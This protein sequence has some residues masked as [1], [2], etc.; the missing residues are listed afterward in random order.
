[1][2]SISDED[3]QRRLVRRLL[4]GFES[5]E[6]AATGL[7]GIHSTDPASVHLAVAAR[8]A[9]AS[10]P[11]VETALY[12]ERR[13]VR[14]LGM[15]R[16]L[17]V[18]PRHL[19]A[20]VQRGYTDSFVA[21]ERK[22]LA[23]WLERT[24]VASDG[25]RHLEKMADLVR[26]F[27]AERGE[28]STR[29]LTSAVPDLDVRFT[30]PVGSA[31]GTVSVGSRVVL[32]MTAAGDLVR[33]RPLGS[34]ISAQYRYTT[35]ERWLGGAI[36]AMDPATA[37]AEL[38]RAWLRR[39]GP[40]T[41]TDLQWWTGWNLTH[42]RAALSAVGVVEVGL[43]SG[44]GYLLADDI[45]PQQETESVALLPA[46]DSTPMGWKE[47]DSYLGDHGRLLFDRN[48]NVGPTVWWNGRIVG[49]WAQRPDGE[50]RVRLLEEVPASVHDQ[51]GEAAHRLAEFV[52]DVRFTPR[53][54][55]PLERELRA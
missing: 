12:D 45:D 11:D 6:D 27:V 54:R 37:R 26:A 31:T 7:V 33:T 23:G 17:F 36:P 14:M 21:R 5:V 9:A 52:G 10:V 20:V 50:I 44:T 28:V 3:R 35:T 51:I 19:V 39:Y 16:T 47:R 34:W 55:T 48:G 32:L 46:L 18:V 49:G 43:A 41:V 2:I 15:R 8:G 24:G 13:L 53:F 4:E 29:D 25:E 38:A 40:G 1:M 22:R 42:T 30:P